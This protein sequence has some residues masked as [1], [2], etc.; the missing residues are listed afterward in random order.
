MA[1]EV[2]V[3]NPLN[4]VKDRKLAVCWA[5]LTCEYRA[6]ETMFLPWVQ[7]QQQQQQARAVLNNAVVSSYFVHEVLLDDFTNPVHDD[8]CVLWL[9]VEVAYF[10]VLPEVVTSHTRARD[11]SCPCCPQ[12]CVGA[13]CALCSSDHNSCHNSTARFDFDALDWK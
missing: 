8:C 2:E 9:M 13:V 7:Q 10:L 4:A 3:C 6:A 5:R 1:K 11:I 12:R